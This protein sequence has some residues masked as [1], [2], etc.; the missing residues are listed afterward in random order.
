M[1]TKAENEL[2]QVLDELS[3]PADKVRIVTCAEVHDLGTDV[4]RRLH[5]LPHRH[6][7]SP[8][9]VVEALPDERG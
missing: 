7:S 4:R 1:E 3:Y 2:R 5:G 8:T 9:E 6:Y